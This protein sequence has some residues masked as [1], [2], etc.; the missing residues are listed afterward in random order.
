MSI[1]DRD[2]VTRLFDSETAHN[3]ALLEVLAVV[4]PR[5]ASQ[6]TFTAVVRGLFTKNARLLTLVSEALDKLTLSPELHR[7]TFK[8]LVN[9]FILWCD[10]NAASLLHKYLDQLANRAEDPR[11]RKP[12][13]NCANYINFAKNAT[14]HIR[15]PF[16]ME[17]LNQIAADFQSVLDQLDS[18]QEDAHLN[19]IEFDK[20][21]LIHTPTVNPVSSFFNP[22]QI[23]HRLQNKR[24]F[25]TSRDSKSPR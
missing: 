6:S 17:R 1:T 3:G 22:S 5:K 9:D 2:L 12:A 7:E 24:L 20:V 19:A 16:V 14:Q 21:T 10:D 15:N 25:L 8:N 11:F 23:V 18:V 4:K 13:E